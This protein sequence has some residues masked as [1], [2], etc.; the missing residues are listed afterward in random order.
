VT[1][2]ERNAVYPNALDSFAPSWPRRGEFGRKQKAF[3][4][5]RDRKRSFTP[6]VHLAVVHSQQ[7]RKTL[8]IDADLRRPGVYTRVGI[9]NDKGMSD[10]VTG[11]AEWRDLVQQPA[12]FP[13]LAVLP[14]G[15]PSRRAETGSVTRFERC[16]RKLCR[17]SI[18]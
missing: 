6:T 17:S 15:P 10:V 16:W 7:K 3:E 8:I 11:N 13:Y 14:A 2:T 18:W 9:S 1:G 12:N 4:V 5:N